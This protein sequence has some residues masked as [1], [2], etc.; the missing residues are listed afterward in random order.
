MGQFDE[1]TKSRPRGKNGKG[2]ANRIANKKLYRE[3]VMS[4]REAM[5]GAMTRRRDDGHGTRKGPIPSQV[6]KY[7]CMLCMS[8]MS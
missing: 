1:S 3:N 2:L 7:D 8:F 6:L 5:T 4:I